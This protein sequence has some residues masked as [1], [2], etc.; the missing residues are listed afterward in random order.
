MARVGRAQARPDVTTRRMIAMQQLVYRRLVR[1][2]P[3][4]HICTCSVCGQVVWPYPLPLWPAL[5][6]PRGYPKSQATLDR[7]TR[8]LHFDPLLWCSA[9]APS[10]VV[11]WW[12]R[13]E[14]MAA[15]LLETLPSIPADV[16]APCEVAADEA[17]PSTDEVVC[18]GTDDGAAVYNGVALPCK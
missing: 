12:I 18:V 14:R 1:K 9:C 15:E 7:H 17:E 4:G 8:T 10:L 13:W 16:E 2:R 6:L 5:R 11:Q 3:A